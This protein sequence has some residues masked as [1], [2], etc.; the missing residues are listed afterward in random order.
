MTPSPSDVNR[1]K[2][3]L[4]AGKNVVEFKVQGKKSSIE[5]GI[6]LWSHDEKIVISDVDGTVTKSDT[7]GHLLPRL[8][9]SD[10]A[11]DGIARLYSDIAQ[12]GY[13][14]IYLSSRPIGYS[15]STKQYLK[16]IK[17]N[18]KYVMPDG[19]LLL[20]PDRL[21]QSL[22]REVI[23]KQ[24]HIFKIQCLSTIKNLFPP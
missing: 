4:K 2:E 6:Y 14:I 15:A 1:I 11:H 19:P 16:G 17:Q 12:N 13:K 8:G 18:S 24:P 3:F 22:Y 23:I 5:G 10:W 7:L 9:M 20:S 21:A